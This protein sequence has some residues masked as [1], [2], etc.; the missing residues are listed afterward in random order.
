LPIDCIF[1]PSICDSG[2]YF[3]TVFTLASAPDLQ[4]LKRPATQGYLVKS[5]FTSA[6]SFAFLLDSLEFFAFA[7]PARYS[8]EPTP[9]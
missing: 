6:L 1:S 3:A 5:S 2:I 7:K 9:F 8:G 4:L